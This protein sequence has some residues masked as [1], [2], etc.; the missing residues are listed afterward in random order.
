MANSTIR[1]FRKVLFSSSTAVTGER[2]LN[3]NIFNYDL[4]LIVGI[5]SGENVP[6]NPQVVTSIIDTQ[7]I[8]VRKLP[9]LNAT[10]YND[11]RWYNSY[12]TINFPTSTTININPEFSVNWLGVGVI[13]VIGIKIN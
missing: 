2:T 6:N 4:L 3:D 5:I 10:A 12:S 11:S 13:K 1:N 7:T 9:V 8:A